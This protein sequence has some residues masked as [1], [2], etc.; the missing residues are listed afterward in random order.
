MKTPQQG[1]LALLP[2]GWIPQ[3]ARRAEQADLACLQHGRRRPV[4]YYL[5]VK[6]LEL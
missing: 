2:V 6:R 3:V 4:V 5:A 1:H